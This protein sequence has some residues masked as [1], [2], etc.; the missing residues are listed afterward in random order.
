MT[1]TK[2][3]FMKNNEWY[4]FDDEKFC[5]MLTDNAPQEAQESYKKFYNEVYNGD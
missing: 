4:Y 1:L 3:Y 5:Y 2:P